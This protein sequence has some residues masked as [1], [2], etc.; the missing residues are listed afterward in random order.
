MLEKMF[1]FSGRLERLPYLGYALLSS[2]IGAIAIF[3]AAFLGGLVSA[4]GGKAAVVAGVTLAAVLAALPMI[5]SSFALT[6]KRLRDAGFPPSI[7]MPAMVAFAL[8]DSLVLSRHLGVAAH[9]GSVHGSIAG[10]VAN[11]VY[12]AV[13]LF[14]PST[15]S[16]SDASTTSSGELFRFDDPEAPAAA[17]RGSSQPVAVS[18]STAPAF[19]S[20]S[21]PGTAFGRRRR[22]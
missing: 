22:V 15:A 2:I 20:P 7:V 8:F 5:W 17:F 13:L 19:A 1:S 10:A 21:G 4:G 12:A 16:V 6:A 3:A 11:L 14:W 9:H 18:I